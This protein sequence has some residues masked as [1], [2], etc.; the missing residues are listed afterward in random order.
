ME[1]DV[2]SGKVFHIERFLHSFDL[3]LC[4]YIRNEIFIEL[5]PSFL[6]LFGSDED[7]EVGNGNS[8]DDV[9]N[10]VVLF[11]G[12][13]RDEL[14]TEEVVVDPLARS[15]SALLAAQYLREEGARSIQIIGRNGEVEGLEAAL[16]L[17]HYGLILNISW[18]EFS[19]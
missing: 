2:V 9:G 15:S 18:Y 6:E 8:I 17:L 14:T 7:A 10:G 11:I 12:E 19:L 4:D 3:T 13:V 1:E 16:L 5:L